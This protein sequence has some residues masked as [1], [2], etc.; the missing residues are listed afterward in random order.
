ME[1]KELSDLKLTIQE[2]KTSTRVK[3]LIRSAIP[4]LYAHWEGFVKYSATLYVTY[5]SIRRL[6]YAEVAPNF[7]ALAIKQRIENASHS[8]AA[9]NEVVKFMIDELSTRLSVTTETAIN[10]RSNLNSEVLEDISLTIGVDFSKFESKRNL[11]DVTLLSSRNH[12]AH[13]QYLEFDFKS[14]LDLHEDV[15]ELLEIFRS[16]IESAVLGHKYLRSAFVV[17]SPSLSSNMPV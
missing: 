14:Y 8:V 13:G 10:T 12:I 9:L 3:S 1:K 2:N 6:K 11:I 5:L 4:V 7:V 16:E 17:Q 15:I